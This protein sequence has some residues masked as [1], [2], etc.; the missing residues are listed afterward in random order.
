M[1]E[2]FLFPLSF[3]SSGSG[4]LTNISMRNRFY[5]LIGLFF[6]YDSFVQGEYMMLH[7]VESQCCRRR[8]SF[9]SFFPVELPGLSSVSLVMFG[10]C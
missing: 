4:G 3:K 5:S 7:L 10:R 8:K 9:P 2:L 6:N 1:G